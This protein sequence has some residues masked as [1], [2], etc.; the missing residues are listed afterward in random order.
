MDGYRSAV[1]TPICAVAAARRRSAWRTSGRRRMSASPSP[2]GISAARC[3]GSTHV[4]VSSWRI[5]RRAAQQRRESEERRAAL[6][7]ERRDVRAH[8]VR[9]RLRALHIVGRAAAGRVAITGD[10]GLAA[11]DL[12][13]VA[14]HVHLLAKRAD[15]GIGARRLRHHHDPD[16]IARGSGGIGVRRRRFD[17]AMHA[18]EQVDLVAD[19][20]KILEQ[21]DRLRAPPG[22]LEDLIGDGV[23]PAQSGRR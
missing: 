4:C 10:L 23:A 14:T 3:G 2:T 5:L 11:D 8:L 6:A 15:G 20:E 9:E 17:L 21:P 18:A 22:E 12:Q 16:G 13:R 7:L 1:A 19:L